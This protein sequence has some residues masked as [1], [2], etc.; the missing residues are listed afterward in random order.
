MLRV[1]TALFIF[2]LALSFLSADGQLPKG[3]TAKRCF[4]PYQF[5]NDCASACPANCANINNPGAFCTLNCVS[6]CSC[7]SPYVF[8][9]GKTGACVLPKACPTKYIK[10]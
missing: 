8:V 5:W 7:R 9:S 3:Q 2:A 1:S 10:A 6:G 4:L